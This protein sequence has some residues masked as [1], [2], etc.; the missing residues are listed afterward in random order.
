MA[1]NHLLTNHFLTVIHTFRPVNHR[2]IESRSSS[3]FFLYITVASSPQPVTM[4][5]NR[6]FSHSE[7]S[8]IFKTVSRPCR[9]SRKFFSSSQ[10]FGY[11][12]KPFPR[13]RHA[14]FYYA[15]AITSN[16]V[17]QRYSCTLWSVW[18]LSLLFTQALVK[19]TLPPSWPFF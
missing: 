13:S 4:F 2:S 18:R 17:C 8:F 10:P 6:P 12:C 3:K 19:E 9:L 7:C 16:S 11:L 5:I 14:L 1:V 15:V